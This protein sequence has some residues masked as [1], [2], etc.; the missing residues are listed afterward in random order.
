MSRAV[1]KNLKGILLMSSLPIL[2]AKL[3]Y[4]GAKFMIHNC[5]YMLREQR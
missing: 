3:N 4:N 2:Y 5:Q 1:K